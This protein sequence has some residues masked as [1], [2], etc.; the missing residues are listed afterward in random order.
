MRGGCH[1]AGVL[2][3]KGFANCASVRLQ[4]KLNLIDPAI[5]RLPAQLSAPPLKA[6]F[7][8]VCGHQAAGTA[9]TAQAVLQSSVQSVAH[10][11][12]CDSLKS[13]ASLELPGD[14]KGGEDDSCMANA[15]ER[16]RPQATTCSSSKV[17]TTHEHPIQAQRTTCIVVRCTATCAPAGDAH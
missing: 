15:D 3:N 11:A 8:S 5:F 12:I 7:S 1:R 9:P 17:S 16:S 4:A 10:S 2:A 6:V 13:S 14:S